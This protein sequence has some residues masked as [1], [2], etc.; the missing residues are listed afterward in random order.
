[1]LPA[2]YR[3]TKEQDFKKTMKSGRAFFSP[4]FRLKY[5]ANQKLHSRFGI[6]AST[7]VSK[8]A[9][10]RNRLKRQV[11]EIIHL[12]LQKIKAGSDIVISLNSAALDQDYR[13]LREKLLSLF[14]KAKLLK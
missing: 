7:K 13:L 9:V 11:R 6:V 2:K 4:W 3:L 1:M 10:D 8:K 14:N 5:F 12:N